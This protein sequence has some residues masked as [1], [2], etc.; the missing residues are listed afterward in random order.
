MRCTTYCDASK[1]WPLELGSTEVLAITRLSSSTLNEMG[2]L[3]RILGRTVVWQDLH[4]NRIKDSGCCVENSKGGNKEIA[5]NQQGEWWWHWE[6]WQQC[7]GKTQPSWAPEKTELVFWH[8]ES[9]RR[10]GLEGTIQCSRLDMRNTQCLTSSKN[11][12]NGSYHHHLELYILRPLRGL[13]EPYWNPAK[14]SGRQ[15]SSAQF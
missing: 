4:F 13:R 10:I 5:W 3:W 2:N 12:I 7:G 1:Q 9:C 11:S 14:G 6:R 15:I 8:G